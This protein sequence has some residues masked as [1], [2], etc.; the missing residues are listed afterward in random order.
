MALVLPL[1]AGLV[2]VDEWQARL[3]AARAVD[4]DQ[5]GARIDHLVSVS[6]TIAAPRIVSIT[7]PTAYGTGDLG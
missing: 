7:F 1:A 2:A 3:I 4:L 6:L 5:R